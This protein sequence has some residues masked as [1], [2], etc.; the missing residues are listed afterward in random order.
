[1]LQ[2]VAQADL[3]E[4]GILGRNM[5][6]GKNDKIAVGNKT[7]GLACVGAVQNLIAAEENTG[8][9]KGGGGDG[10]KFTGSPVVVGVGADKEN[11]GI[12]RK[13]FPDAVDKPVGVA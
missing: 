12:F 1:M 8:L 13:S 7:V 10:G 3:P 4:K 6:A 5:A 9:S 11:P 2:Q